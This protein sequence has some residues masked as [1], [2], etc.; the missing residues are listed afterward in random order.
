MVLLEIVR[1]VLHERGAVTAA[2]VLMAVVFVGIYGTFQV[3]DFKK[4]GTA[5]TEFERMSLTAVG[6]G[7]A[8]RLLHSQLGFSIKDPGPGFKLAGSKQEF[9]NAQYWAYRNDARS[10]LLT[11]GLIKGTGDSEDSLREL[12]AAMKG[13]PMGNLSKP[14]EVTRL[15]TSGGAKPEGRLN[16]W[17]HAFPGEISYRVRAHGFTH[18]SSS[19]TVL[20]AVLSP[21]PDALSEVLDSFQP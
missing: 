16:G 17:I 3:L 13:A 5:L 10:E 7:E 4:Q 15:E 8:R 1:G 11:L 9:A 21:E 12:L 18:D 6:E 2:K 19:Y 14:L 20:V